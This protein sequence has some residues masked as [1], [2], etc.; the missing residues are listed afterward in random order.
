MWSSK[1]Q[2]GAAG[3][4][5]AAR[6]ERARH[7]RKIGCRNAHHGWLSVVSCVVFALAGVAPAGQR[8]GATLAVVRC[9]KKEGMPCSTGVGTLAGKAHV[10]SYEE[11]RGTTT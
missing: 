3:W 8:R 6:C 5:R 10:Q 1:L 11:L 2:P 9:R 7:R 4:Q